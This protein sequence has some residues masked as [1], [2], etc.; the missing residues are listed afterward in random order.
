MRGGPYK[1][2]DSAYPIGAA[3]LSTQSRRAR[4]SQFG[5]ETS[6]AYVSSDLCKYLRRSESMRH[7]GQKVTSGRTAH[8]NPQRITG[9]FR[10]ELVVNMDTS[11]SHQ[12]SALFPPLWLALGLSSRNRRARPA[13]PSILPISA[14]VIQA[15]TGLCSPRRAAGTSIWSRSAMPPR[16]SSTCWSPA[17]ALRATT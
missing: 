2:V 10:H 1:A 3:P 5:I 17:A 13:V 7:A 14:S 8:A 15:V 9:G 16:R 4:T 6:D 11:R 12:A